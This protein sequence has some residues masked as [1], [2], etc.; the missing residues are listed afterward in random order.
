MLAGARA[1]VATAAAFRPQFGRNR[2]GC[3]I[4]PQVNIRPLRQPPFNSQ[5]ALHLRRCGFYVVV[6]PRLCSLQQSARLQN[7]NAVAP[8]AT[9]SAG[10]RSALRLPTLPP[11]HRGRRL[12]QSCADGPLFDFKCKY[13]HLQAVGWPA[14]G[15]VILIAAGVAVFFA[16]YLR[17]W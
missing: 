14:I 2:I 12:A 4:L 13:F 5:R 9:A 3:G 6:C 16:R 1:G 17:M 11:Q 15:G 8:D 10:R 7:P